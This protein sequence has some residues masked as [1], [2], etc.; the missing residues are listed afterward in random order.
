[1]LKWRWMGGQLYIL[2]HF[3]TVKT[4]TVSTNC[5]FSSSPNWK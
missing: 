3:K 5:F 2:D 4:A 1:L